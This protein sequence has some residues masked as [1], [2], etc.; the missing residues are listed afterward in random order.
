MIR[1]LHTYAALLTFANFTI[2]GLVGLTAAF[3]PRWRETAVSTQPFTR[4]PGESDRRTAERVCDLLGLS[5]ATPIQ[6]AV[7][8]HDSAGRLLLDFWHA[9]GRHKVT[10][11]EPEG[12]IRIERRPN[13]FWA[14]LGTLHVTTAAF[15][16]GDWRMQLWADYNEFAMWCF[17][18]MIATGGV[19]WFTSRDGRTLAPT[20]RVHR[21]LALVCLPFL[22]MYAISAVQMAHR[23]WLPVRGRTGVLY[24]LDRMHQS[25]NLWMVAVGLL[26]LGATGLCLWFQNHQQRR[27]GGVLLL[28]T[29]ALT[30]AL[31]V[32]MRLP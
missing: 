11:V 3:V 25:H 18:A 14:Y 28:A 8:Q 2:Y 10:V 22:V 9:N 24:T 15:H 7:M 16:S 20:R 12:Q 5:L 21:Y 32:S 6:S 26:L 29:L 4:P 23:R 1:K 13:S 19:L 31:V 17:V 30:V 27:T